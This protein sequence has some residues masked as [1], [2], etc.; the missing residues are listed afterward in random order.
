MPT[1]TTSYKCVEYK[2]VPDI[3]VGTEFENDP[4]LMSEI[5]NVL[6]VLI[7]QVFKRYLQLIYYFMKVILNLVQN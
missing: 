4:G 1:I 5:E 3:S 2:G 7:M 6:Y